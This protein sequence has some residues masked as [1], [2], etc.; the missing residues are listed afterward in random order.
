MRS[1]SGIA[2]LLNARRRSDGLL[3]GGWRNEVFAAGRGLSYPFCC[4]FGVTNSLR[5][6][7]SCGPTWRKCD[8][9]GGERGRVGVEKGEGHTEF[10]AG[11]L[12]DRRMPAADFVWV[13]LVA[14]WRAGGR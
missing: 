3:C 6:G 5:S 13:C 7:D 2:S 8:V 12:F 14:W 1:G 10:A 4:V 9:A 11:G